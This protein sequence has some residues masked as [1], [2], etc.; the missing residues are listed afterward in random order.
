[1]TLATERL[2]AREICFD[3]GIRLRRPTFPFLSFLKL[4][5]STNTRAS[6][7]KIKKTLLPKENP[8]LTLN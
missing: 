4:F 2:L 6:T 7:A 8:A 5:V 1:L 3:H